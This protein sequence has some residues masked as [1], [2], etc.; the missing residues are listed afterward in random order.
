[1]SLLFSSLENGNFDSY[2]EIAGV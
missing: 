2:F 1:M